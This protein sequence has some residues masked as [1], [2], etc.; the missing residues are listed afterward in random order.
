MSQVGSHLLLCGHI[1]LTARVPTE[2]FTVITELLDIYEVYLVQ[3]LLYNLGTTRL[4]IHPLFTVS[5]SQSKPNQ[6]FML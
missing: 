6:N 2:A 5:L 3:T 4:Y 1:K